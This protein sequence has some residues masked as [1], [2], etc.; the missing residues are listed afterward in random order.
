MA[1]Q[2]ATNGGSGM[3]FIIDLVKLVSGKLEEAT[4]SDIVVGQPIDLGAV[5]IVPLSRLTVGLGVAGGAGEGE[6]KGSGKSKGKWRGGRGKGVGGGSGMGA[7]VRPVGLAIFTDSGVE[8]LP[9]SNKKG[10]ID[11]LLEKIPKIVEM[12][13]DVQEGKRKNGKLKVELEAKTKASDD[14]ADAQGA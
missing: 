11:R 2:L 4:N 7:K 13:E 9:I 14:E 3:D 1:T 8:V 5:T 6:M 12:V 10:I